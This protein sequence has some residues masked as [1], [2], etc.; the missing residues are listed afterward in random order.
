MRAGLYAPPTVQTAE[1][2][3]PRLGRSAD[4]II[5]RT[6][7]ERRHIAEEDMAQMGAKAAQQVLG[8]AVPDLIVNASLTPIQLIPDSSVFIQRA[9]GLQGIPSFSIH[10]TCLSF[11]VGLHTSAALL[12]AGAYQR[13]LLISSEQGSVCRDE[14]EPESAALIGDGAAA[15]LIERTPDGEA[16]ELLGFTMRTWP[17]GANY[18]ELRGCGTFRHPNHAH[19]VAKDNLFQMRGPRIYRMAYGQADSLLDDC[20]GQAGLQRD[21]VDLVI[22]HQASGPMLGVIPRFGF[23]EDKVVNIIGEYGNCIA[24]SLPMALAHALQTGRLQRGMTVLLYGTGA[25]LSMG[26]TLLRY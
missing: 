6:G 1:E 14:T 8:D 23:P 18:T 9:M 12:H 17:S 19:T 22:P 5:S 20:F 24:A 25:G 7:V 4:W 15:A 3:A 2:L 11:M 13:I 10:A 21:D 26:A 16:S